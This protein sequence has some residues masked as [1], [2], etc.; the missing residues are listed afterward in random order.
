MRD[1]QGFEIRMIPAL[2]ARKWEEFVVVS[3]ISS[4]GRATSSSASAMALDR[5]PGSASILPVTSKTAGSSWRRA[6][7]LV[8]TRGACSSGTDRAASVVAKLV[9]AM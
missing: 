4:L 3:Q 7:M 1:A 8:V 2:T 9:T 6:A 5:E